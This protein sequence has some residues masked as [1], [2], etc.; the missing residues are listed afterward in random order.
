M[1]ELPEK[2]KIIAGLID[3][4]KYVV[5]LTGA[6][7]STESGIP[8]FRSPGSGLWT[9]IDPE[10][11]TIGGFKANPG[12]FYKAGAQFFRQIKDAEPN[13]THFVLAEL[14]RRGLIK[15]II[16]QNVDGLHQK[17]GAEKVLEIHGTLSSASC[18]Y[19]RRQVTVEEVIA[20]VEEGL[21]PPLC[22][23]CGEPLKPDVV[24][25][26][27]PLSPDYGKAVEEAQRADLIIVIGSSMQVSPANQLPAWC[28][29]L[30][31]INRT[32]TFYDQQARVV[33]NESAAR[34]MRL[35]LKELDNKD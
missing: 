15:A 26:G 24:L 21:L 29:N 16:T 25:F 4:G 18:S 3:Q 35:L 20:D 17:G 22:L 6:G 1:E 7:V 27:E 11:F 23:E 32:S 9:M 10:L 8:D 30:V 14:E 31:I 34:V 12:A 33:L 5:V 13:E 19:C 28:D 2:I